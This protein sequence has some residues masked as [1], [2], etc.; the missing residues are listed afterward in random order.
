MGMIR[1]S[2]SRPQAY[3]WSRILEFIRQSTGMGAY[4]SARVLAEKLE[5]SWHTIIRDLNHLQDD[6]GAPIRYDAS[7]KG[8]VLTDQAWTLPPV[9]LNQ[10]EVFA[11]SVATRMLQPFRG[12]PLEM[13]L[14][15]LFDKIARSLEGKVTF[16][17]DAMTDHVSILEEDYVPMDRDRWV[18]VA[19]FIERGQTVRMR[20]V[21]FAGEA[22]SYTALP[23]HLVAY[24]G[25]WYV[26]AMARDKNEP[27][28]F[29]LSRIREIGPSNEVISMKHPFDPQAHLAGAFGI[30]GGGEPVEVQLRFSPKVATYIAERQWHP[31]QRVKYRRDGSLDLYLAARGRKELIRWILSWQPDVEVMAPDE[32]RERVR[33]K[34]RA[35]LRNTTP[36]GKAKGGRG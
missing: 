13:D 29:A 15:S 27:A 11:F 21:T 5:V 26:L 30:T 2:A 25:N 20:Y 33:K 18:E 28:T 14:H 32:L 9:T 31:G 16:S 34:L 24:H 4:P 17:A 36:R 35:G 3:R 7:R 1:S 10:R 22:K 6:E 8:Y 19:G 23:L 12:T